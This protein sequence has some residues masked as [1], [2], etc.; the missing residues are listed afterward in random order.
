MDRIHSSMQT[1]SLRGPL[2][3][4]IL[5]LGA[6]LFATAAAAQMPSYDNLVQSR[7]V[8]CAF[9]RGY[10]IDPA[11][12]DR[13]MV[14]GRSDTLTHFQRIDD[15]HALQITTRLAGAR[16]VRIVKTAKYLHYIDHING[17]FLLTTIYACLERDERSGTCLTYGAMQTRQ[18]DS[19][20]LSDPDTV[21]EQIRDAAEPGFCDHSF[22]GLREARKP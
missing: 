19:R 21:Y 22:I 15:E 11:T 16:E 20:V 18:F 3:K 12:G 2:L 8:H 6:M 4:R 14:E 17:M 5:L 9:Y 10:D 1:S 7:M 13:I